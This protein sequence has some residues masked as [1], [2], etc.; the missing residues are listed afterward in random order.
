VQGVSPNVPCKNCARTCKN[1]V[2][3]CKNYVR[4]CKAVQ[5]PQKVTQGPRKDAQGPRKDMRKDVC[6]DHSRTSTRL[7]FGVLPFLIAIGLHMLLWAVPPEPSEWF[8]QCVIIEGA[9]RTWTPT[10]VS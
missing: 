2:R 4:T 6:K 5:G 10:Q 7:A 9:V 8:P 1:Y 3:T